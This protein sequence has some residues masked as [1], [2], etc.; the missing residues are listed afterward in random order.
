M[1]REDPRSC[2]HCVRGAF[3]EAWRTMT[4]FFPKFSRDANRKRHRAVPFRRS[5]PEFE[6]T[7]CM[8]SSSATGNAMFK[9]VTRAT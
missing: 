6:S 7:R 1:V 9:F 2:S 4:R 3:P 5:S 8:P